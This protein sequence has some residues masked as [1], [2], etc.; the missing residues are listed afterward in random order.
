MG[1]LNEQIQRKSNFSIFL[2]NIYKL[3]HLFL[4]DCSEIIPMAHMNI[5]KIIYALPD[6]VDANQDEKRKEQ[7]GPKNR[8]ENMVRR[9]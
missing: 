7:D 9:G 6:N 2:L 3:L 4:C 5:L 1:E 8:I